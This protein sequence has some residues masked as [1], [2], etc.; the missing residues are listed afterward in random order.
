MGNLTYELTRGSFNIWYCKPVHYKY[1]TQYR[2]VNVALHSC[3]APMTGANW[4]TCS[5]NT[6]VS[7]PLV[8][9]DD[10]LEI[11]SKPG[12]NFLSLQCK[13]KGGREYE[14]FRL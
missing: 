4:D 5:V 8:T 2:R 3:Y 11:E 7:G 10:L 14:D 12:E 13:H 6:H 1:I 9:L